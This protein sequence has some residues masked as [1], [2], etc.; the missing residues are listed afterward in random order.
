MKRFRF[1]QEA[2]LELKKQRLR[3]NE[4]ATFQAS[5]LV[6]SQERECE[7][8]QMELQRTFQQ[9]RHAESA[10]SPP[11]GPWNAFTLGQQL[12][13]RISQA[14]R[15]LDDAKRRLSV[16][17]QNLRQSEIE[18]ESLQTLRTARWRAH[19]ARLHAERQRDADEAAVFK[20]IER[21]RG[22]VADA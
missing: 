13:H 12:Q 10:S 18:V 22:G 7:S 5:Q 9:M 20:W 14:N 2:L 1:S 8:L 15:L 16:A 4:S 19:R 21:Q 3:I 17:R 6:A 11:A